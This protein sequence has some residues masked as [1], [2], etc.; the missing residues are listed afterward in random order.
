MINGIPP[1]LFAI[2]LGTLIETIYSDFEPKSIPNL[3]V[4][5][6]T[7]NSKIKRHALI[8]K[9]VHPHTR[10]IVQWRKLFFLRD[11]QDIP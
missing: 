10:L 3:I 7:F 2:R 11:W 5:I 9:Q 8:Q 4:A 6:L 1:P